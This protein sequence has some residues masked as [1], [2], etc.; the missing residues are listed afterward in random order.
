MTPGLL[1]A[2][3]YTAIELLSDNLALKMLIHVHVDTTFTA[4]NRHLYIKID[5]TYVEL[6]PAC[7]RCQPSVT[8]STCHICRFKHMHVGLYLSTC[9]PR[10]GRIFSKCSDAV[11]SVSC[12]GRYLAIPY[13]LKMSLRG[14]FH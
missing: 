7:S 9:R 11:G 13:Q 3:S 4:I 2:S 6:V 14:L 10:V 1:F 12:S 5:R 8:L